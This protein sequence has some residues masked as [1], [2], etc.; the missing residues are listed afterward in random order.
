MSGSSA[1]AIYLL[2][3]AVRNRLLFASAMTYLAVFAM[4][5]V[6]ERPG[7]GIAH[8]FVVPIILA[9]LAT[10]TLVG[11]MAGVLATLL[12][13]VGVVINPHISP[14]E[15]PT[16]ATAIRLTSFVLIGTMIGHYASS[17][18]RLMGGAFKLVEELST[19]ASRDVVTGLPNVR[20]FE[21]AI[22]RR[23]E[24]RAPFALLVGRTT[25]AS[26]QTSGDEGLAVAEKLIR[27][28][29]L[30]SDVAR[31]GGDQFAAV[32]PCPTVEQAGR[33]A[34]EIERRLDFDGVKMTFGWALYPNEGD[35]G[36]ALL[37]AADERLYARQIVRGEWEP[38]PA[39]AGLV[40]DFRQLR[41]Q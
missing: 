10:G 39:S 4:F 19:L 5:V 27:A 40:E 6:V 3:P 32:V 12:Y 17:N 16:I 28:V 2:V 31:L 23:L 29:G 37:R 14:S 34:A 26:H 24:L 1:G 30:D 13:A 22:S 20:G 41:S 25:S 11:A 38:T 15:V 35:N 33:L 8:L 18:R 9:A 36:L 21:T 7:V